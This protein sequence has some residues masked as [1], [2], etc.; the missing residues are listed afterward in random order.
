MDIEIVNQNKNEIE[1]RIKNE[2]IAFFNLVINLANSKKETEFAAIKKADNLEKE[3][4]LYIRSS[5][6]AAKDILLT[7][8]SEAEESLLNIVSDLKKSLPK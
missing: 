1:L 3:F 5:G 7:C 8:I 2:D 4:S 6:K